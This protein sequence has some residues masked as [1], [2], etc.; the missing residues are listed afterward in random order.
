M[1]VVFRWTGSN[2]NPQNNDGEGRRGTDRSNVVLLKSQVYSEGREKASSVHGH[3]G[4]S[5]PENIDAGG[6]L[7]LNKD[8]LTKL[9]ILKRGEF[10]AGYLLDQYAR[11]G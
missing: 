5:Y 11:R 6:V 7:G 3:Y 9:A 1:L 8:E 2:K 4:R 10:F